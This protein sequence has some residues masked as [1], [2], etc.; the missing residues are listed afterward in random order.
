MTHTYSPPVCCGQVH[1]LAS[2]CPVSQILLPQLD[3]S[4]RVDQQ[5]DLEGALLSKLQDV[6]VQ[7][8]P[9][10]IA[11]QKQLLEE[12]NVRRQVR[13]WFCVT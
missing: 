8:T 2:I 12:W 6:I 13:P 10:D 5:F 11:D 4:A 3:S 7:V 1:D 9:Q